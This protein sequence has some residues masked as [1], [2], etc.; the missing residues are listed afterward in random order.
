[1]TFFAKNIHFLR[2][3]KKITQAEMPNYIDIT[4]G[5][6]GNYE[7]S[8]SEPDISK[9][10][11]IAHLFGVTVD[12]LL[13]VDLSQNVHL[14]ENLD[15]KNNGKNVHLNVHPNVLNMVNEPDAPYEKAKKTEVDLLILK[16]LNTIGDDIKQIKKKLDL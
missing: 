5:T 16:Q 14:I 2:K 15:K 3:Q 11:A 8:V 10:I 4:R 9:I 6:W 12:D 13:S 1:M 7:N